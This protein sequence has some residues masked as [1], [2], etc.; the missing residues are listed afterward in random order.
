MSI[1][2]QRFQ[3]ACRM[4]IWVLKRLADYSR[5]TLLLT[6]SSYSDSCII[7]WC[8]AA[9]FFFYRLADIQRFNKVTN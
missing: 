7:S 5:R 4:K 1:A 2:E 9:Q 3:T 6:A 8:N